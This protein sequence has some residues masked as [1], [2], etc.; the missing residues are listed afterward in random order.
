MALILLSNDD[1]IGSVGLEALAEAVSPLGE[2]WVVAPDRERSAISQAISLNRPLRARKVKERWF[3]VDGTPVDCVYLALA[4]LLPKNPDIVLS[5]I[6]LGANLGQDVFYS[7]T[8][9]AAMEAAIEGIPAVALSLDVLGLEDHG[10][11]LAQGMETAARFSYKVAERVLEKKLPRH[12][13]LNVNVPGRVLGKPMMTKLGQRHY[14]KEVIERLDPR[15]KRYYW[16]GGARAEFADIEGSDCNAVFAG[17]I[18]IS[19]LRL[20]LSDEALRQ[21]LEAWEF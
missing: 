10:Q 1:G 19:P 8:V 11:S 4:K 3:T 20:D 7:G 12:T 5:G 2:V 21:T 9:A 16:I 17:H 15:G 18:S 13:L 14:G 6:N